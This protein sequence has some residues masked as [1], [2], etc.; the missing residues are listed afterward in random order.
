MR[1]PHRGLWFA[2]VAIAVLSA[3][4]CAFGQD[5]DDQNRRT[6]ACFYK[7]ANYRGDRFCL[8]EGDRMRMVPEGFNDKIS[9]IRIFGRTEV[10]VYDDRDFGGPS[11]HVRQDIMDLESFEMKPGHSWND[12]IS[13]IDVAVSRYGRDGGD[14]DGDRDRDRDRDRDG[15]RDWDRYRNRD[16]DR[17]EERS[18]HAGACFYKDANFGGAKFCI[19]RGEQLAMVPEGFNDRLS[20]VRIFGNAQVTLFENR[21]FG[22]R[23]LNLRD[24]V[25]NLQSY[26]VSPGH[27]WNDRTSSIRVY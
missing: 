18:R 7:D 21:D 11:L 17:D 4:V 15:D 3:T 2:L 23:T 8:N 20:S 9:S 24:N 19:E 1:L 14:R 5:R 13:S 10:T 27:S 12:K 25:N 22:G 16:W 6:G 26:Q